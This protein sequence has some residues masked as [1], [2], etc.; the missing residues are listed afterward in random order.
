LGKSV[1]GAST[2][3]ESKISWRDVL[4][5]DWQRLP[6]QRTVKKLVV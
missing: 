2:V 6:D 5:F 1:A 4:M 3:C